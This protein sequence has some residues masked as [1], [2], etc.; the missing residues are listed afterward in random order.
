[1]GYGD[2]IPLHVVVRASEDGKIVGG[3]SAG[4]S[5]GLLTIGLV[6]LPETLRGSGLGARMMAMA[7]EEAR[8]GMPGDAATGA[9]STFTE[10]SIG[11]AL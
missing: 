4:T 6:Y 8:R 1:M 11:R 10:P 5:L 3:I 7:E 9:S 2:R